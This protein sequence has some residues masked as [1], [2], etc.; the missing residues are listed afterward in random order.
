MSARK[1]ILVC[2]LTLGIVVFSG[3]TASAKQ[4]HGPITGVIGLGEEGHTGGSADGELAGPSGVAIDQTTERIYVVDQGNNRVEEYEASGGYVSKFTGSATPEGSFSAPTA[5]AV[6]QQTGDVYVVDTGH[7][8][9]D[10]FT[11]AGAYLC[12]LSGIGRG[13]QATPAEPPTFSTPIGVAVDPTTGGPSSGDVYVSDRENRSVDV[14]TSLGADVTQFQPEAKPWGLA[15]DAT[16]DIFAALSRASEVNEYTVEGSLVR[17]FSG[18]MRTVGVDLQDGNIFI[19]A[20]PEGVYGLEE[21][22]SSGTELASFGVG[23]MSAPGVASPGLAVSSATHAVYA[24]DTANNVVDVFGL[25][26]IPD[27]SGC[28]ATAV[29]TTTATLHGEVN[30]RDTKAESLFQYGTEPSYGLET[31]LSLVGGGAEVETN[32]PVEAEVTEL[33]PGTIYHCRVNATNS[34]GLFN[35]G[36]DGTFETRPLAPTVDEPPAFA[37]EVTTTDAILNGEVNPGNGPTTYHFVYG[38]HANAYT[39][40]LPSVGIGTGFASVPVKQALPPASLA[41][42]TTYHFALIASNA[43]GTVTGSDE[44][45]TTAGI[46]TPPETPPVVST[47]PAEAIAPNTAT[48]TGTAYPEGTATICCFALGIDPTYG[49]LIFTGEA[50][51]EGGAVQVTQPVANLQ[52]GTTYHY[53]LECFN[54]AGTTIGLDRAFTTGTFPQEIFQPAT[55]ALVPIPVFPKVKNPVV[56]HPKKKKKKKPKTKTKKKHHNH[57][58]KGANAHRRKPRH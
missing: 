13:C 21:F 11:S 57:K 15:V 6:D 24:A 32:F 31:P 16:G 4:L 35:D 27:P 9:V 5:V 23:L 29:G 42:N 39:E 28:T 30:P 43:S 37:T 47:G 33:I 22:N 52:P 58:A 56:K 14:F 10:K 55:A 36:A 44:T 34:T 19:G 54:A 12:E 2:V 1:L 38:L 25:V 51:R 48:L 20:E 41:P 8:V 46:G 17:G 45:F 18:Q 49:T 50:G 53:R 7:N 40:T 3:A 26:T